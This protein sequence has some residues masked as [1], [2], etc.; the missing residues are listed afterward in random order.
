MFSETHPT[1]FSE[2]ELPHI[3]EEF[4]L[5]LKKNKKTKA[6]VVALSGDLG[7]GKTTFSKEVG[8]VLGVKETIISPTFVIQK[9]YVTND[10]VFTQFIHMDMYRIEDESEAQSLKLDELYKDEH[11]LVFVEWPEKIKQSIPEDAPWFSF[12]VISE[13]V[14]KISSKGVI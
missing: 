2:K 1:F 12:E 9:K 7:S 5:F 4:V 11:V 8:R 10:S 3:A 13:D 14:R 6:T